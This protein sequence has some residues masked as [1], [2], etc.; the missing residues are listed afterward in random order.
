MFDHIS[1]GVSDLGAARRFY[2]AALKPL[3]F[4]C[5]RE[6]DDSLGYGQERVAFWV[7]ATDRPVLADEKFGLH[8]CFQALTPASVDAFHAEA[9][10]AG[11]RDNGKPGI[12]PDYRS[13]YYTAF[14]IDPAGYR[15]EAY[16]PRS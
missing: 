15:V 6:S 2:D 5:L 11:G 9:V 14:V 13:D 8:F 10:A 3:G 7:L 4:T 1:I 16:C 12:R